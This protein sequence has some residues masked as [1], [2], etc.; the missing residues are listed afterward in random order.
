MRF[1]KLFVGILLIINCFVS[2]AQVFEVKGHVADSAT[3]QNL[4]FVNIIVNDNENLG[5]TTDIDGNFIIRSHNN[6]EKVSFSYIGYR[7]KT[8]SVEDISKFS[9]K[10]FLKREDIELQEVIIHAGN[11]PAHRIID[12]VVKY[13][14]KNN[15]E[16]LDYYTYTIFDRMILTLDT[17]LITDSALI[18][19]NNF[20][21]RS[22]LMVM[23]TVSEKFHK[24]PNKNKKE[25]KANIISGMSNPTYFYVIENIQS[26]NFY[27]SFVTINE[28]SYVNPIS[29]GSTSKYF[30]NIESKIPVDDC[31]TIFQISFR[32]RRGTTFNGLDGVLTIHSDCWAIANVKA[33]PASQNESNSPF[34]PKLSIQQLYSKVNDSVWFPQQLNTD[35]VFLEIIT[36]G[37]SNVGFPILPNQENS[38]KVLGIGKSYISNVKVNESINDKVFGS[39]DI[40]FAENSSNRDDDFW[41]QY[42]ND[43]ASRRVARTNDFVKRME[44]KT[45]MNL[46]N[47][48]GSVMTIIEDGS[49]PIGHINL[50]INNILSYND[51]NGLYFGLGGKTNQKVSKHL[52]IGA[53]G[54]YWF[55][56]KKMNYGGNIFVRMGTKHNFDLN[57]AFDRKFVKVGDHGFKNTDINAL[58]ESY[59][60][61]YYINWTTLNTSAEATLSR[62]FGKI[63]QGFAKF[64]VSGIDKEYYNNNHSDYWGQYTI[65][66][67]D[68]SLRIAFGDRLMGTE[69]GQVVIEKSKSVIWIGYQKGIKN[70]FDCPYNFDK[71][72]F[73]YSDSW[74]FRYLGTTAVTLQSGYI[75]GE[76]PFNELFGLFGTG[77]RFGLYAS[78]SFVTMLPKEFFCDRF[79][80]LFFS[81]NFG[82]LFSYKAFKPELII[83]TNIGIGD[84]KDSSKYADLGHEFKS[85]EKGYYESGIA[86][87]NII[88]MRS[89]HYGFAVVYRYGP[90]SFDKIGDNFVY[91]FKITFSL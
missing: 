78:E 22:D 54:G 73:N 51:A 87:G 89:I 31:D 62:R 46:D 65:A 25:I 68:F 43:S 3:K 16:N 48:M 11:N 4:A 45:G 59:F 74:R 55:R 38:V 33:E 77:S 9:N 70:I 80:A 40:D 81:H 67:L 5:T 19:I 17:T 6:I 41:K 32:P 63:F 84:L 27:N 35:I 18:N 29:P 47:Y 8:L 13:R 14:K 23:E 39:T 21:R 82:K 26:T 91:K 49:I 36:D 44:K 57:L 34:I 58:D 76:L 61:Y 50:N 37:K 75:F 12:S 83:L 69:K 2:N 88:D 7:T 28:K 64:S 79:A 20:V 24:K 56:A 72:Q 71:V 90:Y 66:K 53:Y 15:P 30:F 85:I 60:K 52:S 42:R 86:L 10:I 1:S